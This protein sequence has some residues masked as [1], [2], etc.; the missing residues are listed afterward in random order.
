MPYPERLGS[1]GLLRGRLVHVDDR[2]DY[3]LS[4]DL[5]L[6][7]AD[8]LGERLTAL[9][10]QT[11]GDVHVDLAELRFLGSTGIRAL[12]SVHAD[13]ADHG[14]RLV[15]RNVQ[16][17]PLRALALTGLSETLSLE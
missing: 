15:L 7:R 17:V 10:V 4:G 12:L 14:R 16:G 6:A 13:L 3:A 2:V 5:D 8:A 11:P 1:D 9:A